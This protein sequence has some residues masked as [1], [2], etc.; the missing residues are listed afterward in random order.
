[1]LKWIV[2]FAMLLL[3]N[4][5]ATAQCA[6]PSER[7]PKGMPVWL[8]TEQPRSTKRYYYDI[9]HGTGET[10]E[11]AR[12]NAIVHLGKKRELATGHT[13]NITT[14]VASN[15]DL[16]VRARIIDEYWERCHD[17][18]AGR[19]LFH[20]YILCAVANHPNDNLNSIR[21]PKRFLK[22][23]KNR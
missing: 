23:D 3:P 16:T 10:L 21:T 1:M 22:T 20:V 4:F 2:I 6:H 17:P 15:P 19:F 5:W 13:I 8:T 12:N 11:I 9:G 14:G 18:T 7:S